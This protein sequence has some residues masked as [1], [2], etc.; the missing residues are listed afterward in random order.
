M[1]KGLKQGLEEMVAHRKGKMTLRS[2]H[3][4]IPV[5]PS[6]YTPNEIVKIRKKL[7]YSQ[8]LF[9]KFLNVSIK[10]VQAWESG[11][12]IPSPHFSHILGKLAHSAD[13]SCSSDR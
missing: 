9:A 5:P 6:A 10:T 12:R 2:E 1:F 4:E 3:I 13:R 8:A 7:G 11:D